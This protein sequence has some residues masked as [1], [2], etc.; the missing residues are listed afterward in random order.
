MQ[1]RNDHAVLIRLPAE[2]H[3]RLKEVARENARSTGAEA[4]YR[5]VQQLTQEPT[6]SR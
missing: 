2:V 3:E 6:E 4:R 1:N 5:L